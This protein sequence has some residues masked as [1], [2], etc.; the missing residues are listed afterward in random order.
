[1][2]VPASDVEQLRDRRAGRRTSTADDGGVQAAFMTDVG[3]ADSR[4]TLSA[5]HVQVTTGVDQLLQVDR[6]H[7]PTRTRTVQRTI[8][9]SVS[10]HNAQ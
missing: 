6:V 4:P 7:L 1:M 10:V 5:S 8:H 2:V 3:D 9:P